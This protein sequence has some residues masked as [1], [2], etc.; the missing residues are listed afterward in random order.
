MTANTF[1]EEMKTAM[2]AVKTACEHNTDWTQCHNCPF[3]D[4]CNLLDLSAMDNG[5]EDCSAYEPYNWDV[6]KGVRC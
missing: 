2:Q 6:D 3:A 5:E 4:V 1:I